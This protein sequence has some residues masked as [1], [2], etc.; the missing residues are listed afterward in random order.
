[1]H[2]QVLQLESLELMHLFV[3]RKSENNSAQPRRAGG[4]GS[5]ILSGTNLGKKLGT[6]I[7]RHTELIC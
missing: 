5:V 4:S 2:T 3:I 6:D 7:R 1:M